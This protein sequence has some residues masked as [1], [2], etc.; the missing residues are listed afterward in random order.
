M[1]ASGKLANAIV[2]SVAGR[3]DFH[4]V[5]PVLNQTAELQ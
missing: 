5:L 1:S 2:T 3:G 4:A